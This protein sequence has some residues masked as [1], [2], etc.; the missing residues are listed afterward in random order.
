MLAIY[1][2]CEELKAFPFRGN[3]R[4]DISPGLRTLGFRRRS[5]IAFTVVG[6][7]VTVHG[8]Y[9]GGQQHE[10]SARGRISID[11]EK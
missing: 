1:S 11:G 6:A 4:D 10:A 5:V 3:A 2:T 7:D 9:Y 8:V